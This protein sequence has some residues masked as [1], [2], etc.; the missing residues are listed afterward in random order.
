MSNL[1]V[2]YFT[3]TK[4]RTPDHWPSS[5]L[6]SILGDVPW[7]RGWV[8]FFFPSM[9]K[10]ED[11]AFADVFKRDQDM[12]GKTKR[13]AQK[14]HPRTMSLRAN[15]LVAYINS[16]HTVDLLLSVISA[17]HWS[18]SEV[19]QRYQMYITLKLHRKFAALWNQST[20]VPIHMLQS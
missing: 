2:A 19:S 6:Q 14:V 20:A 17:S 1:S 13:I 10:H 4:G 16:P 9:I 5:N 11:T 18:T 8:K 15:S 7:R 12:M 3:H